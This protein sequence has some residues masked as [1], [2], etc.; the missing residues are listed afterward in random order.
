MIDDMLDKPFLTSH[1]EERKDL[2]RRM[3][4]DE[5]QENCLELDISDAL[6]YVD[7]LDGT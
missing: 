5:Y 2:M 1:I 3:L 7:P 4:G 6:I